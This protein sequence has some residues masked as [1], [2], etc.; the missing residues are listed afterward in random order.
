MDVV[1]KTYEMNP[2][3]TLKLVKGGEKIIPLQKLVK[4]I[5]RGKKHGDLHMENDGKEISIRRSYKTKFLYVVEGLTIR[6]H[7]ELIWRFG[8]YEN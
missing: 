2:N 1:L 6:Q 7:Y 4:M 3:I 5:S 8:A